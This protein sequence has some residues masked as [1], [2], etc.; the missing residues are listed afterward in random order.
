MKLSEKYFAKHFDKTINHEGCVLADPEKIKTYGEICKLEEEKSVYD[1]FHR[2]RNN[3]N[4]PTQNLV[5]RWARNL[6]MVL[7]GIAKKEKL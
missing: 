4:E 6:A 5:K 1:Y 2:M 7:T 3:L